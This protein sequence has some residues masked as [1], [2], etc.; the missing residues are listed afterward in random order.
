M[1]WFVGLITAKGMTAQKGA[2]PVAI[3]VVLGAIIAAV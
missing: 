3:G 2:W 1:G